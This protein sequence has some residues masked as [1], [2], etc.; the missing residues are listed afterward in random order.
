MRELGGVWLNILSGEGDF[1]FWARKIGLISGKA[2][3]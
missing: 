2:T 3:R 1:P